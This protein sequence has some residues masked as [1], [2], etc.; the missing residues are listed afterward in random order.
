MVVVK[1]INIAMDVLKDKLL[2]I[3]VIF[4][5]YTNC[6][7]TQKTMQQDLLI[8]KENKLA[9]MFSNCLLVGFILAIANPF[10][11]AWWFSVFTTSMINEACH[12]ANQSFAP[13]LLF[14]VG[15]AEPDH[16]SP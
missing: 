3:L 5:F 15:P 14:L 8:K 2:F 16:F 12:V 9:M 7:T 11:I 6:S 4:V 13:N 10:G 1:S